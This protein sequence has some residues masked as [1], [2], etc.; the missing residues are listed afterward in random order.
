MAQHVQAGRALVPACLAL[1]VGLSGCSAP[2]DTPTQLPSASA[3]GPASA[4]LPAPDCVSSVESGPLP[5]WARD[6]FRG[7]GSSFRHAEG[8][9]GE[10]VGVLFGYPL[11]SPPRRSR[12][13]KILWVARSRTAGRLHIDAQLEGSGPVVQRD[14]GFGGGQSI[15]DLPSAGC[16]RLMLHW[17]D[18]LT[19][20]VDLP[21]VVPH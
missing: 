12:Q 14:V 7:D 6:G 9:R 8:L 5:P 1:A 19:D 20:V 13:N 10:V 21:Y 4:L 17:G 15:I 3:S 18:D 2:L 11:T 16:W